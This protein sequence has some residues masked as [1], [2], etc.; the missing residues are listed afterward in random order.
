[1]KENNHQSIWHCFGKSVRGFSHIKHDLPNQD[2]IAHWRP[3]DSNQELPIILA[4]ADGHGSAKSFRSDIG[5]KKAVEAAIDVLRENLV[6]GQFIT[7][8]GKT[9]FTVIKD[10]AE[11]KIP[12]R[13]VKKWR[14]L[15]EE[16][17]NNNSIIN[18]EWELLETR[19]GEKIRQL[20]QEN[21]EKKETSLLES[22]KYK[23][24]QIYGA[25]LLTVMVT[26]S[27]IFYLQI[28][29]GDMLCID[30]T[31]NIYHPLRKDKRLIANDTT[32]LCTDKSWEQ[33]QVKIEIYLDN[34][35]EQMPSLILLSTDGY[36]NSFATKEGFEAIAH[37]Y[38]EMIKDQGIDHVKRQL[39]S[40]LNQTSEQGSGD[41]ITLG[42]IKR[43]KE[44]D[45]D[46]I[47]QLNQKI[48]DIQDNMNIKNNNIEER[49]KKLEQR[50]IPQLKNNSQFLAKLTVFGFFLSC[51]SIFITIGLLGY[52]LLISNPKLTT[53]NNQLKE[54]DNQ[55]Q[56]IQELQQKNQEN[57]ITIPEKEE[58]SNK[59]LPSEN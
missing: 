52:I 39:D 53:I 50:D 12:Q 36:S 22:E 48:E 35:R 44:G 27:Y 11:S 31:G 15:I 43:I 5:S 49:L 33:F 45:C 13:I 6:E 46:Y 30:H 21:I 4:I 58:G 47:K 9:N 51:I 34:V 38:Q 14:E 10:I 37:D 16:H 28:G 56:E 7:G 54:I 24:T 20:I 2:A 1:M 18:K 19:E 42:L 55:Q 3:S 23:F 57:K 8:D 29:D 26:E 25:T 41:D 17:L 59:N 40:Y 32:S